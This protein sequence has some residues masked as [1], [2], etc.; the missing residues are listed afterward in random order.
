MKRKTKLVNDPKT[1]EACLNLKMTQKRPN[2]DIIG[3]YR[4]E[5]GVVYGNK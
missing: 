1:S 2:S 4:Y 3:L 5:H